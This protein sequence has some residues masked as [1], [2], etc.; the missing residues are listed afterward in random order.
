MRYRTLNGNAVPHN[1]SRMFR[2]TWRNCPAACSDGGLRR[3]G[4]APG[5]PRLFDALIERA[6]VGIFVADSAGACLYANA[7]L[8]ELTGLP[9]ERQLGHGWRAALH[10]DD[11]ERVEAAWRDAIQK[12][13][14]VAHGQR[15]VRPDRSVAWVEMTAVPIRN[16]GRVIGWAGVCVDV[17]ER[18]L[19]ESRYQDLIENARDGVFAVD[20]LGGIGSVNR[21]AEEMTGYSRQEL[22]DMNVLDLVAAQDFETARAAM[23]RSLSGMDEP[24]ITLAIIAKN[25]RQVS[26]DLTGRLVTENDAPI[27]WEAIARDVTEQRRL[28][29]QLAHQAF[30]DPLTG[31]PNRALL[32]DRLNQALARGHR[33]GTPVAAILLD[34]DNFKVVNDSLGHETGDDLLREV[35]RR[36]LRVIRDGDTV[37]RLGGDEFALVFDRLTNEG[38]IFAVADRIVSELEAPFRVGA[39]THE[40]RASLGIALADRGD[41]PST[42]LRN[43]D[44]AMYSAKAEKRGSFEIFDNGMRQRLLQELQLKGA[45]AEAIRNERLELHY[46]PIVSPAT[47]LVLAVEALT[48]W[49]HPDSGWIKPSEF[50]PIAERNDLIAPL[51]RLALAKAA[52]Q[53]AVWHRQRPDALPLGV[54]V[55]VSPRELAAPDYAAFVQNTLTELRLPPPRFGLEITERTFLDNN[56]EQTKANLAQLIDIGVRFSLDD[57]GTGY[58]NLASLK[59]FPFTTIKID[60]C[61]VDAIKD[62]TDSAPITSAIIGLGDA[63]GLTVIAEGVETNVQNDYLQ[64][65]GCPAAQGYLYARPQPVEEISAYLDDNLR[66]TAQLDRAIA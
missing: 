15:F 10:F 21:A 31:L 12:G 51:G 11:V 48:R 34:L 7:V 24:R 20:P 18:R 2:R 30:H 22:L 41:D 17:T 33:A 66:S 40:I 44:T 62:A 47:G 14:D 45:L 60:R 37:A 46:Q 13:S 9:L 50:I 63:L 25:G 43:A 64:R 54:F 8:C 61:F 39:T 29:E 52:R 38:E 6:P 16:D 59:E 19:S 55:N 26:V 3:L 32:R 53:A 65:L 23:A 42:L 4:L 27:R 5:N 58:S 57:F 1:N 35:A 49:R 56:N 28:Q 36:L